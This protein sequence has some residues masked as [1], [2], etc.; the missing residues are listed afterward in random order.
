VAQNAALRQTGPRSF[1]PDLGDHCPRHAGHASDHPA[2]PDTA[3]SLGVAAGT[4]RLTITLYLIG[5]A[6]GQ[7]L[8]GPVSDRPDRRPALFSL[9]GITTTAALRSLTRQ[10]R[11]QTLALSVVQLTTDAMPS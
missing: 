9:A 3:R 11:S 10:A 2:L 6:T 4:I 1:R 8:Y 7:L 5:Q